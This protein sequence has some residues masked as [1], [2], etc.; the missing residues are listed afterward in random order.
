MQ[1][2]NGIHKILTIFLILVNIPPPYMLEFR[3]RH[4]KEPDEELLGKFIRTGD[5]EVLGELYS[6]YIHLVY[7]VALKYL[8]NRE[9]AQDAVMHIFEKLIPEV[10]K[11]EIREFR[12]W[13]YVLAKNHCL[14]ELRSGKTEKRRLEMM[15][16]EQEFMESEEEMHP[17][18]K[19]DNSLENDLAECIETLKKEQKECIRLFYYQKLSYQE[20]AEKLDLEEKKVKSHLQNGKRNLKICLEE[21]DVRK[22]E[23]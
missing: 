20:I 8:Q 1:P 4:S 15:K 16:I 12:P 3:G 5:L 11:H 19:E 9:E 23:P 7:G 6:R 13:L 10:R 18:D 2:F 22:E 21:K 14:M 17:I